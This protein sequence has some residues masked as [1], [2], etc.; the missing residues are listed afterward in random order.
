MQPTTVLHK[1]EGTYILLTKAVANIRE[2]TVPDMGENITF[3]LKMSVHQT[4]WPVMP[5]P[6][7]RSWD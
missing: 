1:E 4:N 5:M 3:L 2:N 6:S 7:R